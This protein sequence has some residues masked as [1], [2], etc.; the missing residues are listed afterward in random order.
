MADRTD[1]EAALIALI[2]HM[3]V[4]HYETARWSG[5]RSLQNH[6]EGVRA[7]ALKWLESEQPGTFQRI[8]SWLDRLLGLD[9]HGENKE[10]EDA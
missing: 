9:P 3:A 4:L 1:R 7:A 8:G 6:A 2:A 5:N 10:A